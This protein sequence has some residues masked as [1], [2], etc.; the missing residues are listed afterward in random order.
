[1][2]QK[3]PTFDLRLPRGLRE[4][5]WI[6]DQVNTILPTLFC[7]ILSFTCLMFVAFFLLYQTILPHED[8]YQK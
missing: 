2:N 6:K 8:R 1:M 7:N 4:V 5:L 3:H